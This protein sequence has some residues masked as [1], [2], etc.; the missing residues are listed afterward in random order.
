MSNE[1]NEKDTLFSVPIA[2]ITYVRLDTAKQVFEQIRK[3]RPRKLY[4]I[5]DASDDLVKAEKVQKVRDYISDNI[6]WPC[7]VYRN[8]AKSNMGCRERINSG[9]DWV[10]ENEEMAIIL[11]DDVVPVQSFF[12]FCEDMLKRYKDDNRIFMITGNKRVYDYHT[13]DDYLFSNYCSIWGWATWARAWKLNESDMKSWPKVKKDKLLKK[14]YGENAALRLTRDMESVYRGEV[15][16]WDYPWQLSKLRYG[17][18]EIVPSVNMIKNIGMLSEEA[19]HTFEHDMDMP[20]GEIQRPIRYRE[21]VKV[22]DIYDATLAKREFSIS[23]AEKL[24]RKIIPP[25]CLSAIRRFL[26]RK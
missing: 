3:I 7:E 22:D 11:E 23:F 15:N 2:F 16:T 21:V 1:I 17:G 8:Y 14:V 13:E 19:T 10:F 12:L 9:L 5:S 6:D 25:N 4:H 18:L 20:V 24:I 26:C